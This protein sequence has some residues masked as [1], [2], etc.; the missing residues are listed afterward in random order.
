MSNGYMEAIIH[1]LMQRR[2]EWNPLAILSYSQLK[3][4]PTSPTIDV[5]TLKCCNSK[6]CGIK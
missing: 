1:H 5:A 4:V 2:N 6:I 3:R